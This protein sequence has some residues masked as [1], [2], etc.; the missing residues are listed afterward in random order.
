[1]SE[2]RRLL[3][4]FF[5]LSIL[6]GCAAKPPIPAEFDY[7]EKAISFDLKADEPLNPFQG[8]SHTLLLCIYQMEDPNMFKQLSDQ[9]E[10]L[11]EL[12]KCEKFDNAVTH[13]KTVFL[14]PKEEKKLTLDRAKGT[15]YVAVVAGYYGMDSEK[16]L[17]MYEIP[18]VLERKSFLSRQKVER[19]GDLNI[20]LEL[21][22]EEIK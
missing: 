7:G 13:S 22:P 15:K 3:G 19:L 2:L 12:L 11:Y 14:R 10:G 4:A 8:S 21:G 1:M 9:R 16:M 5:L 18:I 17:R 6:C 20:T